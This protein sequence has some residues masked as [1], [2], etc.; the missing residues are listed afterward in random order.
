MA[1]LLQNPHSKLKELDLDNSDTDS[2]GAVALAN[3]LAI[4]SMLK[5]L[6]LERNDCTLIGWVSLFRSLTNLN[7][8]LEVL[9]IN[10][11]GV[12]EGEA[13]NELA[14]ALARHIHLNELGLGDL[15]QS[16]SGAEWRTFFNLLK[17]S[18]Y[19]FEELNL[20]GSNSIGDEVVATMMDALASI[21]SL[22]A[23]RLGSNLT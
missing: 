21:I 14:T 22:K 5:R 8:S 19:S 23:I 6:S 15:N 13:L 11:C 2:D 20:N 3:G 16:I 17:N 1:N 7:S 4:N 9:N 10:S 12:I 18:D